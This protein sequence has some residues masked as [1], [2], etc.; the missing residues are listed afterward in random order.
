MYKAVCWAGVKYG[1]AAPLVS[2]A[3][4]YFRITYR[5]ALLLCMRAVASQPKSWFLRERSLYLSDADRTQRLRTAFCTHDKGSSL[6]MA[7][8]QNM[9][10]QR[11][12]QQEKIENITRN[13][14]YAY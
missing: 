2:L 8:N 10:R 7:S 6:R 11:E 1:T 14:L 9:A 5:M 12:Q 4:F 13:E 3:R